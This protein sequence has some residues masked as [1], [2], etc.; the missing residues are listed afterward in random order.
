MWTRLQIESSEFSK[1]VSA[2]PDSFFRHFFYTTNLSCCSKLFHQTTHY[3][4]FTPNYIMCKLFLIDLHVMR[5]TQTRCTRHKKK[6]T[7]V[8]LVWSVVLLADKSCRVTEFS[9]Y[10]L[11]AQTNLKFNETIKIWSKV[12]R[13]PR[14]LSTAPLLSSQLPSS[15]YAEMFAHW[16]VV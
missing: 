10:K 4:C 15:I 1:I 11:L 6:L 16:S 14:P 13:S 8:A 12:E 9:G 5:T 2:L 3:C 7:V